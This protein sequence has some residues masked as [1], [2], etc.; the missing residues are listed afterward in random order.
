MI[1]VSIA[2]QE[3]RFRGLCFRISSGAAGVGSEEG[4]GKPPLG[5]FSVFS[6]HGENAPLL[7]VFR[8]RLPVGLY[9]SAARGE[10]AVLTRILTLEGLE[11]G[12]ANTRARYIY[13]HATPHTQLLGSPA[14]HGCIRLAPQDMLS[15]FE[16]CPIGTRV[17][18]RNN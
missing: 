7:T 18:I 5:L 8:G 17:L 1:E 9:P 3:L 14:S 13:I 2:A 11:P 6:R 4:S 15:L 10:D 16:A 12:N